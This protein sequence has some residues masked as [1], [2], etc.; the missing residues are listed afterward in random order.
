MK[1]G[2]AM[3]NTEPTQISRTD[4]GARLW[5]LAAV[6]RGDETLVQNYFKSTLAL[7]LT[8]S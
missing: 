6:E 8:S 3:G 7:S 5:L 1:D 2:G 4:L